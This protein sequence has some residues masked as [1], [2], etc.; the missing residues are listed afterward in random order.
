MQI[1]F[2]RAQI[3]TMTMAKYAK[4]FFLKFFTCMAS[5]CVL[6]VA[7]VKVFSKSANSIP[8]FLTL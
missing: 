5:A 6:E 3:I 8:K 7:L 4:A 2:T 1:L